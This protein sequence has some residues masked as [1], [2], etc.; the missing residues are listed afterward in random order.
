MHALNQ[1]MRALNKSKHTSVEVMRALID[2]M[3]TSI[4]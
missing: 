2:L 1:S 4:P 3:R